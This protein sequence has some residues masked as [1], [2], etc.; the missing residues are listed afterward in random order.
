MHYPGTYLAGGYNRLHTDIGGQVVENEDLVNLPNWLA[1][2]FRIADGDWFDARTVTILEYR[3]ELDLRRGML[4]RTVRCEDGQGRRSTLE[5]RRLV[6]MADMHLGALEL[7]LAAENWS[8]PVT[9]RTAI[10][11]RVVNG[12]AKLYRSFNNRH[13]VPLA[14]EAVG[15]DTVCL[16][17]RTAQSN[18]RVARAARTSSGQ[19]RRR[20]PSAIRLR[21]RGFDGSVLVRS[22]LECSC[23]LIVRGPRALRVF[24]TA[25][26]ERQ[27]HSRTHMPVA[28]T[29]AQFQRD[30]CGGCYNGSKMGTLSKPAD[31]F[32]AQAFLDSAGVS[33]RVAEYR[34]TETIFAQGDA[35]KHVLY[36]QKGGV[37][38]S[39]L[40]KAGRQAV[41]AMLGPG[42]FFGEGCLAGHAV[43]MGSA[44]ATTDSTI[45][46]VDKDQMGR[47]LHEEHA[48]S[49]RFIT[50]MLNRNIRIEQDLVDQLFNSSEKRLARTL[51]LLARYG[52]HDKPV[53]PV[54]PISQETLAEMI[55]TT[56]SRVNFF[57]KKFQRLGFIDY[58]DGLKVNNSL[59]TV[60]LHEEA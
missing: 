7:S 3:Q 29:R 45:L 5:E 57:M 27:G 12:G 55:G 2:Q 18:I 54:L 59:L 19:R 42:D 34:R 25:T 26:S 40:S 31:A 49:D 4:S 21:S 38:L 58:T 17:V 23:A 24:T 47:L 16:L 44:T 15:D 36:I 9:I 10:D 43:R 22:C 32:N 20:C 11:G 1:L 52:E 13:L 37:K 51:L 28:P 33:R 50:H 56:R 8:A 53:R 30:G 14:G 41:V 35:C 46:L 6:S 39:V 48:L 60:V